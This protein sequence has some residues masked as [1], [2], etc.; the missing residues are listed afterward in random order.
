MYISNSVDGFSE[1]VKLIEIGEKPL[2]A[3]VDPPVPFAGSAE[4]LQQAEDFTWLGDLTAD[5]PGVGPMELAG[6][7]FEAMLCLGRHCKG[8]E[9]LREAI[10]FFRPLGR[11][12]ALGR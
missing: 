12:K 7:Q 4:F 5:L 3:A 10:R 1:D 11:I 2:S 9:K 6:P 8:D